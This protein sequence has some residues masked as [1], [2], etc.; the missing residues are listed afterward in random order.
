MRSIVLETD[1]VNVLYR[2]QLELSF[3]FT[4]NALTLLFNRLN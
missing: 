1:M 4:R 3:V 2:V